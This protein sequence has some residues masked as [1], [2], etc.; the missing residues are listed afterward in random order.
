MKLPP[1]CARRQDAGRLGKIAKYN[2]LSLCALPKME[3]P[4][5][6]M[7]KCP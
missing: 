5:G 6:K 3:I 7:H 4:P 1:A 2:N